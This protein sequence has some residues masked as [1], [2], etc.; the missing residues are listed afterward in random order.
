MYYNYYSNGSSWQQSTQPS[1][2]D[3]FWVGSNINTDATWYQWN[4]TGFTQNGQTIENINYYLYFSNGSSWTSSA[5]NQIDHYLFNNNNYVWNG[6]SAWTKDSTYSWDNKGSA[7]GLSF[8]YGNQVYTYDAIGN[9]LDLVG[10]S[11]TIRT[12]DLMFVFRNL[13]N[14]NIENNELKVF[15]N[16]YKLK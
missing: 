9:K 10:S 16:H 13:Q 3:Y 1:V 7:S 15:V 4:G 5:L 8:T 2:N 11:K 14:A 12:Q 6:T